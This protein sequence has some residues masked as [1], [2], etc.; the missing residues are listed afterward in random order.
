[1]LVRIE[2]FEDLDLRF[3]ADMLIE[4][5][6]TIIKLEQLEECAHKQ[7]PGR[8]YI[9]INIDEPYI[10]E[11]YYLMK[12]NEIAKSGDP[13]ISETGKKIWKCWPHGDISFEEFLE[14]VFS[15]NEKDCTS[16]EYYIKDKEDGYNNVIC[17]KGYKDGRKF[18]VNRKR[19][20]TCSKFCIREDAQ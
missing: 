4:K 7:K 13:V 12:E 9:N 17:T 18:T 3:I 20:L 2:T 15:E 10:K 1:M 5:G 14:Q 11:I 16:C 19:Y 8:K 6:I